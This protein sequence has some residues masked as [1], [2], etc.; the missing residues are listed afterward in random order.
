MR[1]LIT[2]ANGFIGRWLTRF[3]VERGDEVFA[4]SREVG[5]ADSPE[6][7]YLHADM[8]DNGALKAVFEGARPERV[9]HLAAQSNIPASFED[10]E[11][12]FAVNV[13]GTLHLL[14]AARLLT[15]GA[16]VISVGSSGEYGDSARERISVSEDDALLPTSPYGVSKVTQGLLC[17]LAA[18]TH[19]LRTVHAR[20]FAVIGPGKR[21]DAL[22]QFAE[23]V[24]K[25]ETGRQKALMVGNLEPVR[26]FI[27]VR[28]CVR[29]LVLLSEH[30][31]S[32]SVFNVCNGSAATLR[33]L[34]HAL[35]AGARVHFDVMT[36]TSRLRPVDDLRIVGNPTKLAALGYQ[37]THDLERTVA[38][39]LGTLRASLSRNNK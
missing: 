5:A 2:G 4:L 34:V 29:A 30:A 15:P 16:V 14:E 6:V 9:F 20:P 33:D 39:T 38:D 32:G 11:K 22:T 19:G 17:R 23:Q 25:I 3:L 8:R 10:P 13:L 27:D 12:T 37:R 31:T 7:R 28:D 21:G 1:T 24:V 26:D 18:K 36:D 35:Q